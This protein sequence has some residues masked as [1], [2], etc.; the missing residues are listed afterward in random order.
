MSAGGAS[1]LVGGGALTTHSRSSMGK[2]KLQ[3]KIT[4]TWNQRGD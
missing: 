2:F 4:G 3:Y 1:T